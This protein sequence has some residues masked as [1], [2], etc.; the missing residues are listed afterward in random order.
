MR[1]SI[2]EYILPSVLTFL[3]GGLISIA[4]SIGS[5]FRYRYIKKR[6][7]SKE[8]LVLQNWLLVLIAVVLLFCCSS[9]NRWAYLL[10]FSNRAID[11]GIVESFQSAPTISVFYSASEHRLSHP[12]IVEISGKKYYILS[13]SGLEEGMEIRF[14]YGPDG[15]VILEWVPSE[16]ILHNT[17][18]AES[19]AAKP[20]E[21]LQPQKKF[22]FSNTDLLTVYVGV[23]L[24]LAV[25]HKPLK[26]KQEAVLRAHEIISDGIVAPRA[27]EF[28]NSPVEII[29]SFFAV[30]SFWGSGLPLRCIWCLELI[31][32]WGLR[33]FDLG[34][35]VI[36]SEDSFQYVSFGR[37]TSVL[38][39]EISE[40]GWVNVKGIGQRVLFVDIKSGKRIVLI[41]NHYSGLNQLYNWLCSRTNITPPGKN[42]PK[43]RLR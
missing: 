19:A 16:D 29:T 26:R 6:N 32:F 10:D 23:L 40:F 25:F 1:F 42:I 43:D 36:Y 21:K 3:I 7:G 15:K 18:P 13:A 37:S 41:Q 4:I 20:I 5:F 27:I 35:Y 33:C 39:G 31:S 9:M 17:L 22:F 24:A 30:L 14:F 28:A 8:L 11:T 38:P 2:L 12:S 34:R